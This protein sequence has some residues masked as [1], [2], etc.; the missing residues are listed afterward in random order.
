MLDWPDNHPWNGDMDYFTWYQWVFNLIDTVALRYEPPYFSSSS[1]HPLGNFP[2]SVGVAG[3]YGCTSLVVH[4]TRGVWLSHFW[5]SPSF[6]DTALTLDEQ[7]LR[8]QQQV[9][10]ILG[11]GDGTDG[12]PGLSQFMGAGGPFGPGTHIQAVIITPRDRDN[13]VQGVM[14]F[15][16]M[17]QQIARTVTR[18][19]GGD[20]DAGNQGNLITPVIFADYTPD[21]SDLA[22]DWTASGKAIF[23]YDPVQSRCTNPETGQPGQF[24]E[25]RLWLENRESQITDH[26]WL[27]WPDQAVPD[28]DQQQGSKRRGLP[29]NG[30]EDAQDHIYLGKRQET[31]VPG[32]QPSLYPSCLA[33]LQNTGTGPAEATAVLVGPNGPV[34]EY[35]GG[36]GSITSTTPTTTGA[37][38]SRTTFATAT[39]LSGQLMSPASSAA[40]A[41]SAAS[42]VAASYAMITS[43]P[44]CSPL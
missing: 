30:T 7:Q 40:S 37:G 43:N 15:A 24:A 3:L 21:G 33:A 38:S 11:P 16:G 32:V 14:M 10:N 41:V 27:V 4:S 1:F 2:F 23:Q 18:L 39:T 12:F 28:P 29:P 34:S 17:A 19:F 35:G 5:E 36:S 42:V 44:L 9:I 26:Y 8:F 13:P 25:A 20:W 22:Q 6:I 31:W